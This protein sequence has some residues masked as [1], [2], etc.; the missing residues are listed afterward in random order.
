MGT[1]IDFTASAGERPAALRQVET[2][3]AAAVPALR[4]T[5]GPSGGL[6]R[7]ALAAVLGGRVLGPTAPPAT[8]AAKELDILLLDRRAAL[9]VQAG[10]AYN[11]NGALVAV[12]G[13]AACASVDW[14]FLLV[15][16]HYKTSQT[17]PQVEQQLVDLAQA[18]GVSLALHSVAVFGY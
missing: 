7:A 15:P 5:E 8:F 6:S 11:N 4:A 17:R 13:A 9:S 18:E 12:L 3:V 16:E 14:L 2:T 1:W 10:R